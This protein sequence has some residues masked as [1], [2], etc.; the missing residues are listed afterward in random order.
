MKED[1][2]SLKATFTV[3]LEAE[4]GPKAKNKAI[5][6]ANNEFDGVEIVARNFTDGIWGIE[7]FPE[8]AKY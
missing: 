2:L 8:L 4:N 7:K 6:A 1:A 3:E 5:T